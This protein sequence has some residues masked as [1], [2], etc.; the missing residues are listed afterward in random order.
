MAAPEN[1]LPGN[2][3]VIWLS[4]SRQFRTTCIIASSTPVSAFSKILAQSYRDMGTF[5]DVRDSIACLIV[6]LTCR[7]VNLH[8]VIQEAVRF[9]C[10]DRFQELER[11]IQLDPPFGLLQYVYGVQRIAPLSALHMRCFPNTPW[12]HAFST[13]CTKGPLSPLLHG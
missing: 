5:D 9:Y 12:T 10:P 13:K 3:T 6:I 2:S 11:A 7:A 1:T 4:C 8:C